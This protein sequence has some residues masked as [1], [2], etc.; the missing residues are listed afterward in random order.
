MRGT[1]MARQWK[2]IRL[3]ETH[4]SGI[5]GND[6]ASELDALQE[7]GFPYTPKNRVRIPNQL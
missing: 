5:S 7:A 2:I 3:M 4:R 1:Q 6:L